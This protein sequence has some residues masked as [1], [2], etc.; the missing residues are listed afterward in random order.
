M[1]IWVFY[2]IGLKG[3][4]KKRGSHLSILDKNGKVFGRINIIDLS[5]IFLLLF[6]V[7]VFIFSYLAMAAKKYKQESLVKVT[8]ELKAY[9]LDPELVRALKDGDVERDVSCKIIGV[10]DKVSDVAPSTTAIFSSDSQ[11]FIMIDDPVKKDVT[12]MLRLS[13]K[14]INGYLYYKSSPVKVGSI[15]TFSAPMYDFTGTVIRIDRS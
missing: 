11:S 7:P 15:V 1:S 10:F 6:T 2:I 3:T 14:D 12:A 8:V 5:V 13:C 9:K 4:F